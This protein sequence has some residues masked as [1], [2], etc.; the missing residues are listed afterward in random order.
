MPCPAVAATLA[1][2]SLRLRPPRRDRAAVVTIGF[3][4][5]GTRGRGG[6]AGCIPGCHEILR[7][8]GLLAGTWCLDPDEKLSPGQAAE[9]DRIGREHADLADDAFVAR[10]LARWLAP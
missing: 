9:L 6:A 7:R 2:P 4:F 5:H 3:W 1:R 10:N 8:Q